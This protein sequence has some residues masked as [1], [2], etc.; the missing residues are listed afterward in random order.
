MPSLVETGPPVPGREGLLSRVENRDRPG[1]TKGQPF[2]PGPVTSGTED[3]PRGR[4]RSALGAT[5]LVPARITGRDQRPTTWPP[6]ER[7]GGNTF[8]PGPYNGPRLIVFFYFLLFIALGF[9][10]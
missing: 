3:P 5:P 4:L 6:A 9:S 2:S 8:S 10:V 1:G 7:A